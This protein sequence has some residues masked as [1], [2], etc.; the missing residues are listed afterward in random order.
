[1]PAPGS[2][3]YLYSNYSHLV[4]LIFRVHRLAIIYMYGNNPGRLGIINLLARAGL[5]VNKMDDQGGYA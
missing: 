3:R 4:E 1:M 5:D 2:C